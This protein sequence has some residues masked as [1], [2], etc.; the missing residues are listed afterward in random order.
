MGL[1]QHNDESL[2]LHCYTSS[3]AKE[4]SSTCLLWQSSFTRDQEDLQEQDLQT[5]QSCST[6]SCN[7][8]PS[9]GSPLLQGGLIW[10]PLMGQ[11]LL[12]PSCYTFWSPC[13]RSTLVHLHSVPSVCVS[14]WKQM[15]GSQGKHF[16]SQVYPCYMTETQVTSGH[17]FLPVRWRQWLHVFWRVVEVAKSYAS[18]QLKQSL[19]IAAQGVNIKAC[20]W[21][22]E[23]WLASSTTF[24]TKSSWKPWLS[25][26]SVSPLWHGSLNFSLETVKF[27]HA[28]EPFPRPSLSPSSRTGHSG[29][30]AKHLCHSSMW[31]SGI[32]A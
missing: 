23:A 25:H 10:G 15:M 3:S 4:A 16:K 27:Q 13:P 2:T 20:H 24:P 22:Q 19:P 9:S 26:A 14:W 17:D 29:T 31:T 30:T 18:T 1:N 11:E 21:G 8:T 12:V 7:I 5:P 32:I 6:L 28:L